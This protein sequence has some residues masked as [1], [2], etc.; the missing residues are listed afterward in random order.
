MRRDGTRG[1]KKPRGQ[2]ARLALVLFSIMGVP[3]IAASN[4]GKTSVK[5][6]VKQNSIRLSG[7]ILKAVLVATSD[8]TAGL[9]AN[10]KETEKLLTTG[11][12]DAE[13]SKCMNRI[14]SYDVTIRASVDKFIIVFVFAPS[15]RCLKPGETLRGVGT[16]YELDRKDFRVLDKKDL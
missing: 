5:A 13:F 12:P 7:D 8:F 9:D 6:A 14:E 1:G 16:Q 4:G 3:A 10:A 11:D 15:K 2:V